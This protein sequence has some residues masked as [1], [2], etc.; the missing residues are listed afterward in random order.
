MSEV[1]LARCFVVGV[2][3]EEKKQGGHNRRANYRKGPLVVIL[4]LQGGASVRLCK[5]PP[6]SSTER[7]RTECVQ[8]VPVSPTLDRSYAGRITCF[9][10]FK[11]ESR[12][13][14]SSGKCGL[15][16]WTQFDILGLAK[17]P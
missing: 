1:S 9:C 13:G 15:S 6:K 7:G 5:I 10:Q 3:T 12:G 4:S 2:P 11:D 17:R 16:R 14:T 8:A